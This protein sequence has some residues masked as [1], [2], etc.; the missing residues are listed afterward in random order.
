MVGTY[1]NGGV[2]FWQ[3][4]KDSRLLARLLLGLA[5]V[6]TGK[7]TWE[8]NQTKTNRIETNQTKTGFQYK[9]QWVTDKKTLLVCRGE[10]ALHRDALVNTNSMNKESPWKTSPRRVL[11]HIMKTRKCTGQAP[12]QIGKS[13]NISQ[14]Y[15][16]Q[17]YSPPPPPPP[18]PPRPP[19]CTRMEVIKYYMIKNMYSRMSLIRTPLIRAR[20]I[21]DSG[22]YYIILTP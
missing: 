20:R 14:S 12:L 21:S 3:T 11:N 4:T 8:E 19:H 13:K 18:P 17:L 2:K 10:S 1:P 16:K 5:H 22:E 6:T 7:K 15:T 9:S